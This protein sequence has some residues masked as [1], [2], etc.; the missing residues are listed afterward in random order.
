MSW[1]ASKSYE[2][3]SLFLPARDSDGRKESQVEG[4]PIGLS[5]ELGLK[6]RGVLCN[7]TA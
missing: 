1:P 2:L 3:N 5:T 4:Y 6:T 7:W